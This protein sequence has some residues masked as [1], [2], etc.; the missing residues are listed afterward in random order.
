MPETSF[1]RD[2]AIIGGAGHV[3]LPLALMFADVGLQT[4]IYDTNKETVETIRSG[5][6][7]FSEEGGQ[8]TL[9]RVR[10]GGFLAVE[11]SPDLIAECE[12]LVLVIGTPVDE[13][14]NPRFSAIEKAL[15]ACTEY[16][17]DG[18]TLILRSTVFP[19]ISEHIQ[20]HFRKRGLAIG[21]AF[22]PERVTQGHSLR[23]FREIPQIISAFDPST[24]A[25]VRALFGR[26]IG[27]LIEMSPMEAELCKLMNNA[28]RYIQFAIVNQFYM[29]ATQHA[30][31]FDKIL[32]GCRFKYPR[33]SDAPGPGFA[34]GPCL[35]KDTMQLAA[36]S[37][38]HFVLGHSAM[39]INE[40]LPSHL[41]EMTGRQVDLSDKTVGILGMAFKA[42]SD[43]PRDS[44]SYKLRKLLLLASDRVLC[45]DPYV[46]DNSFVSIE[47]LVASSDV[48]F[49]GAPHRAYRQLRLRPGKILV[50]VWSCVEVE[51]QEPLAAAAG[52]SKTE[53]D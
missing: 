42:E 11:S 13:H 30:L 41:V 47:E 34:A 12:F 3:G 20:Q 48:V 19:G 35:V 23:E 50:D 2:V 15:D 46:K 40:G 38:N 36:F 25:R 49:I 5:R 22:C 1:V 26:F 10:A 44:L 8:Q 9:E 33:M 17:R 14:L 18:Q 27:D 24:L 43:D 32:H 45:S 53:G 21:V 52:S 28:W 7:P 29:I 51:P 6:M 39:L 37:Q 31:D 16:L 4:V